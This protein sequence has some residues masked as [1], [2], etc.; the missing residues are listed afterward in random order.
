MVSGEKNIFNMFTKL[1]CGCTVTKVLKL[2]FDL[3][4]SLTCYLQEINLHMKAKY[5]SPYHLIETTEIGITEFLS[6]R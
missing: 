5:T 1:G 2:G 3:L 4:P 6:F